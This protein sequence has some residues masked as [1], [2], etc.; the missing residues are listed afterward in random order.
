MKKLDVKIVLNDV[1]EGQVLVNGEDWSH[2]V[3][4]VRLDSQAGRFAYVSLT[5][6]PTS[7]SFEA[8]AHVAVHPVTINVVGSVKPP[9]SEVNPYDQDQSETR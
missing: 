4:D 1:G 9:E 3:K 5:L 6:W 2:R 8:P 7:V